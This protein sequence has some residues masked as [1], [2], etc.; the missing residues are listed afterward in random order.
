MNRLYIILLALLALACEETVDIPLPEH[1]ARL[2]FFSATQPEDSLR[3]HLTRSYGPLERVTMNDLLI[4]NAEVTFFLNGV[5]QGQV[6][7]RDTSLHSQFGDG[8][9]SSYYLSLGEPAQAGDR[10]TIEV[11]HPD[12]E[13]ARGETVIPQAGSVIQSQLIQNAFR[14]VSSAND[15]YTQSLLRLTFSNPNDAAIFYRVNRA[16][17]SFINPTAPNQQQFGVMTILG[18]A[19]PASDGG[20]ESLELYAEQPSSGE[21]TIDFLCELPNAYAP[22]DQWVEV[23]PDSLWIETEFAN[24]D[25]AQYFEKLRAQQQSAGG[26]NLTPAEPVE[27]YSNVEGGHGV[28]GSFIIRTDSL[29]FTE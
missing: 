15:A 17:F 5:D 18:P 4:D 22:V 25:Y 16:F 8:D 10:I 21:I 11:S 6:Q 14:S 29:V 26:I 13:T 20:F 28:V 2:V 1:T 24:S 23:E 9:S 7:Y 27:L 19:V 12:F 3:L